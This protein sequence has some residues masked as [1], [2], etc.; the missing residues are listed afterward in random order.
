[1]KRKI[2]VKK[3]QELKKRIEVWK[4]KRKTKKEENKGK[5]RE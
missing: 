4:E 3:M 1:M 2:E 5:I